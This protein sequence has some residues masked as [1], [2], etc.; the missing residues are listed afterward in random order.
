MRPVILSFN[1]LVR[2]RQTTARRRGAGWFGVQRSG[3]GANASRVFMS[4][5]AVGSFLALAGGP[6][7]ADPVQH[8]PV[9]DTVPEPNP[10]PGSTPDQNANTR[11]KSKPIPG[12]AALCP[13]APDQTQKI[14]AL[15]EQV[16]NA[17]DHRTAKL[18]TNEM[19]AIW[20]SAP[21]ELA[22]DILDQGM[23]KRAS[24]NFLGAQDD[25]DRLIAYCPDYAEGYNQRAF[26]SFINGDF[27]AALVDLDLA[28][29]LAPHHVA[30]LA[31]RALTLMGLG[32]LEEG[33]AALRSVLKRHPWLPERS[34]LLP[35]E[36]GP[37][38]GTKL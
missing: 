36:P 22:Q 17:P 21:D 34:H 28:I 25:F 12:T 8:R 7:P 14:E 9:S 20:S 30:A 18:I 31:G 26:V 13:A 27:P 38:H 19:W 10:A 37:G 5:L 2:P 4:V 15:L 11:P 29:E 33:Q 35:G 32:Q 16:R 3:F 24:Y 1:G 23:R 6:V